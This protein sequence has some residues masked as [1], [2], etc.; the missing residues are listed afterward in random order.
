MTI[1]ETGGIYSSADYYP[2]G[3]EMDGR[4]GAAGSWNA[5]YKFTCNSTVVEGY[6]AT[7]LNGTDVGNAV[8][9]NHEIFG[10]KPIKK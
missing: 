1:N 7:V 10:I 3:M 5:G 8:Q 4:N 6:D 9:M 2:F